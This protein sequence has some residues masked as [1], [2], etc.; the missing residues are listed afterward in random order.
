MADEKTTQYAGFWK[1]VG[2]YLVDVA[3]LAPIWL[4]LIIPYDAFNPERNI[5]N[6]ISLEFASLIATFLMTAYEVI[7]YAEYD[8][9]TLGKRVT[10]IK[11]IME[12]GSKITYGKALLRAICEYLSTAIAGLG[13]LWVAWDKKKQGW[14]DKISQTLVVKV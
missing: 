14:H 13:Y 11:V 3:V 6:T 5:Q 2:A 7:M 1:R 9:Q 12:D 10:G 4:F 8:G